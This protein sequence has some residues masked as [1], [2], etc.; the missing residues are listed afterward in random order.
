[1]YLRQTRC[2]LQSVLETLPATAHVLI[3]LASLYKITSQPNNPTGREKATA[4]GNFLVGINACCEKNCPSPTPML[5]VEKSYC[6]SVD[7]L[8]RK[9]NESGSTWLHHLAGLHCHCGN[10]RL[11][12]ACYLLFQPAPR[13]CPKNFGACLRHFWRVGAGLVSFFGYTSSPAPGFSCRFPAARGLVV[14]YSRNAGSRLGPRIRQ[15]C[16]C[17][18]QW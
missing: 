10:D 3:R 13:R 15:A 1:M 16:A 5:A 7:A 14:D 9:T 17:D 11:G 6:P 18:D 8:L 4:I 2:Y 12:R